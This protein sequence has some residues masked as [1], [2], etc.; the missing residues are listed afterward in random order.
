MEGLRYLEGS[1]SL[2]SHS[3][4]ILDKVVWEIYVYF[5]ITLIAQTFII[6]NS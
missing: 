5:A 4:A 2:V 1:E 6:N 3:S